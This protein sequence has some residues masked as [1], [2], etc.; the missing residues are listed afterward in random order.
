MTSPS[1]F[2]ELFERIRNEVR[3][4]IV[5]QDTLIERLL[6][7]L[8]SDGHIL[9]EGV[10]GLAKTRILATLTSCIDAKMTRLQFTPDLLPSDLIGTEVF[11]PQTGEFTVRKGPLFTNLLLADEINRA[12]AKV[13]SALLQAMQEREVSIGENTFP[14]PQPFLVFAT[15]NPIEHEGTYP[16]PEA[17]LDRFLMKVR[18]G[19]PSY[20][21]EVAIL[22]V[23]ANERGSHI[24][25]SKVCSIPELLAARQESLNVFVDPRI[26]SYIVSIV[27]TT[28]DTSTVGLRGMVDWGASPRAA[29]ALKNCARSLAFI[30]GLS[31]TTPDHVKDI[32]YDVLRHRILTSFDAESRGIGSEDI[33]KAILESVPV[34]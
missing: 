32:A 16:L 25:T 8:V 10:P 15:Q 7:A 26:D 23:T 9:V 18:V 31:T 11:R 28:R 1:D 20:D 2:A 5:G 24:S 4:L 33:I 13:Q 19:Y 14:L 29:I 12:P 6:V 3:R 34:P 22:N 21:E 17:Q 27:Q 30:R